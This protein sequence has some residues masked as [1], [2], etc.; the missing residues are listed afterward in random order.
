MQY[1][2]LSP[3]NQDGRHV[4]AGQLI[5]LTETQAVQLLDLK[6]IEPVHKPFVKRIVMAYP[7]TSPEVTAF[8][9]DEIDPKRLGAADLLFQ[10]QKTS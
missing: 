1:R 7:H 2:T 10:P 9:P 8:R 6:A 5:E 4:A 3:L